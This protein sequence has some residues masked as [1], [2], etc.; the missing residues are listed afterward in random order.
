MLIVCVVPGIPNDGSALGTSTRK[1]KE[2]EDT[3]WCLHSRRLLN[4][5]NQLLC[6]VRRKSCLPDG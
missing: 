2:D 6:F 5:C 1:R 4:K 3:S